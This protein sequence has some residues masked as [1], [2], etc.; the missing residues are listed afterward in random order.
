MRQCNSERV[1]MSSTELAHEL[2]YAFS[3][4]GGKIQRLE[5]T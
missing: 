1:D 5:I 2:R 4:D 3:L